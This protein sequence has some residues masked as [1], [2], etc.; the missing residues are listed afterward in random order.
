M[1]NLEIDRKLAEAVGY[2]YADGN[3]VMIRV[4][5]DKSNVVPRYFRPSWFVNDA[6]EVLE[7][8]GVSKLLLRH[9]MVWKHSAM[10]YWGSGRCVSSEGETVAMALCKA[11]SKVIEVIEGS[12]S[13]E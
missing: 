5:K 12:K 6:L 13:D 10:V 7:K 8:L 9:G 4:Y 1:D 3:E 11:A 2:R